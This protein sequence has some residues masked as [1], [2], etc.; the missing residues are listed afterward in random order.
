VTGDGGRAGT[1]RLQC[2]EGL[3]GLLKQDAIDPEE[4]T[5]AVHVLGGLMRALEQ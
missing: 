4:F 1:P 3:L 2:R 5:A